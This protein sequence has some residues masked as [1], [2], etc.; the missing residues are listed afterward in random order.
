MLESES[1][2]ALKIPNSFEF[3]ILSFVF[4]VSIYLRIIPHELCRAILRVF[5]GVVIV[6]WTFSLVV[7][8]KKAVINRLID[9]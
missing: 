9:R 1:L 6:V 4:S 7:V 2:E 8:W 5:F 3:I